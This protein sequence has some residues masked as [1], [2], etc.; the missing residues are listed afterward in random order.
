MKPFSVLL[1]IPFAALLAT[2]TRTAD[3]APIE[4]ELA[5]RAG[6]GTNP[7]DG[8][9]NPL[10]FGI[11]ARG[12]LSIIG[13]YGGL[14]LMYYT[15]GSDSVSIPGGSVETSAHSLMY[16]IEGGFN[17]RLLDDFL[18]LRPQLGIGNYNL[19]GK[20]SGNVGNLSAEESKTSSYLYL[21][22][23][24]V[25]Y[26]AFGSLFVGADANILVIPSV[27]QTGA[28]GQTSS[29]TY[30]AFTLHGQVGLKF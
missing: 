2:T 3:A 13:I 16:G 28:T 19:T 4:V 7:S 18:T 11:G 27:D 29:K 6:V 9:I 23:G 20:G 30:T 21:E 14:S 24:V 22:P 1:A 17:F 25:G 15:G 26:V 12:G 10:G 8:S 5:G